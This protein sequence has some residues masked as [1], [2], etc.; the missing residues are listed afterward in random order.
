MSVLLYKKLSF[1]ELF[2][3]LSGFRSKSTEEILATKAQRHEEEKKLN[4]RQ[5]FGHLCRQPGAQPEPDK[6]ST[7]NRRNVE[8]VNPDLSGNIRS[9]AGGPMA[10]M[11]AKK[12]KMDSSLRWNDIN[13]VG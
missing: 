13:R 2:E 11:E 5:R 8:E 6:A 9:A 3:I 4:R 7:K 10:E 12:K 1:A